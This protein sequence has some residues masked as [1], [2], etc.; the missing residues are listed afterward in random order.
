[1]WR[2]DRDRARRVAEYVDA[3]IVQQR[4][5]NDRLDHLL[6]EDDELHDLRRLTRALSEIDLPPPV[7]FDIELGD[8]LAEHARASGS[9]PDGDAGRARRDLPRG[10]AVLAIL[11]YGRWLPAP[12]GLR[13]AVASLAVVAAL[14]M[15]LA[16]LAR[17]PVVS[18]EEI[19]SRSDA[20]LAGLVR[21]G[22][23][24]YRRWHRESWSWDA[25]GGTAQ[26]QNRVVHEWMDGS[27]FDRVAGQT[28]T[29][30]GHLLFAY[31]SEREEGQ[32]RPRVY[33]TP[34][35]SEVPSGGLHV[36]PTR[37]ELQQAVSRFEP[38]YW[39]LLSTYVHRHYI[40]RPIDGER[41]FNRA[42][43]DGSR[44]PSPMRRVIL[45]F[46]D[47]ATLKGIPVYRIRVVDPARVRFRWRNVGPPVVRLSR[48]ETVRYVHR[49][50]YLTL[51]SEE[52]DEF[53]DGRRSF[54]TRELEETRAI[55]ASD[56]P[57]DPF[58]LEVPPGTPVRHHS[59]YE[60]LAEV[61]HALRHMVP[62]TTE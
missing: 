53:E 2:K 3:L 4:G 25:A 30:D 1:M 44:D 31:S 14:I 26:R 43:L 17:A 8:R 28:F 57:D 24:L 20:A 62:I 41:R 32:F 29:P 23:V 47:T 50:N 54:A 6:V 52:S 39:P 18:A 22:E 11:T 58:Q 5:A 56:L 37:A 36:E 10:P 48:A 59:A 27:D 46:D 38:A 12:R 51:K 15:T 42:M 55:E 45:S 34:E 19:L 49:E 21:P 60:L 61:A 9:L 13:A 16:Q 35:F 7:S 33:F 40:F